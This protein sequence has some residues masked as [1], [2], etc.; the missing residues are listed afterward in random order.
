MPNILPEA[1]IPASFQISSVPEMETNIRANINLFLGAGR[2]RPFFLVE[3]PGPSTFLKVD[4]RLRD[5]MGRT[6]S[7]GGS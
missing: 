7:R 4:R 2:G 1:A 6:P 3:F 5:R